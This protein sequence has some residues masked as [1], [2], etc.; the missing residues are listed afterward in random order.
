[1]DKQ[2]TSNHGALTLTPY[3]FGAGLDNCLANGSKAAEGFNDVLTCQS[4]SHW[5]SINVKP[6]KD[7]PAPDNMVLMFSDCSL[8]NEDGYDALFDSLKK[9]TAYQTENGYG[10]AMWMMWPVFGGGGELDFD[11]KAVTAYDNYT[12]FGKAYQHNANGG[13]RQA[14]NEIM[15]DQLDCDAS[16]VYNAKVARR[17]EA[18]ASE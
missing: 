12:T 10:N 14:L 4:H 13:G 8:K 2:G 5:A 1:M 7:G 6:P 15:G 9:A 18:P 16:R 3:Y 17:M 11:F